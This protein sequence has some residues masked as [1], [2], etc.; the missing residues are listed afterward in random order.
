MVKGILSIL[1]GIGYLAIYL[2]SANLIAF[3]Y[4][5]SKMFQAVTAYMSEKIAAGESVSE[6]EVTELTNSLLTSILEKTAI[7]T[8]IGS[9]LALLVLS[10]IVVLRKRSLKKEF[11]INRFSPKAILPILMIGAG[12]NIVVTFI[13]QLIQL[14]NEFLEKYEQ[15]FSAASLGDPVMFVIM[16]VV[17]APIMEELV[18]RGFVYTR[19]KKG[20]PVIA[21]M[22][23]SAVLFG[24][25]HGFAIQ[26]IYASLLGFVL[27][28]VFEKTQ[29]IF[30]SI[31]LHFAFNG[32]SILLTL[33]MGEEDT[34]KGV[35]LPIIAV[36]VAVAG[37]IW[38]A[39]L[40]A[41]EKIIISYEKPGKSKHCGQVVDQNIS[42]EGEDSFWGPR[43]ESTETTSSNAAEAAE[44][45]KENEVI[46]EKE[47]E[48]QEPDAFS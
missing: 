9:L 16:T 35:G 24:V 17:C 42:F 31:L 25:S 48:K 37:F 46:E 11:W 10:L 40:P 43:P 4:S 30:A 20:I 1:K 33:A 41:E 26:I 2:L 3:V 28:W 34:V 27:V 14:P 6:S 45:V 15:T 12:S 36:V 7:L 8:I 23:L 38:F 21:A 5:F 44:A 22:I 39:K 19:F 18:F 13:L 29:S 47:P 32:T